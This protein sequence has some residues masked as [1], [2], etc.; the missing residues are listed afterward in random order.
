MID[1]TKD[2]FTQPLS[3]KD[4]LDEL[5]ISKNRYYRT[6]SISTDENLELYL[7]RQPNSCFVNNYFDV[8][9]KA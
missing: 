4:I 3:M 2:N 6:L 1:L 8:S 9:L 7:K 5:E